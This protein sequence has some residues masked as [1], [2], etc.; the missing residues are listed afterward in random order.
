VSHEHHGHDHH[1]HDDDDEQAER[2]DGV[3]AAAWFR[4]AQKRSCP[5][6]G[7]GGALELGGGLFC[8]ACGEVS[9]NPGWSPAGP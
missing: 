6:C 1:D 8:P 5:A 2:D 4:S 9:T 3:D 7:A